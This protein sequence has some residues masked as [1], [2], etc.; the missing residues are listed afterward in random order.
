M[1]DTWLLNVFFLSMVRPKSLIL[2]IIWMS[3]PPMCT[4]GVSYLRLKIITIA[5]VLCGA[6]FNLFWTSHSCTQARARLASSCILLTD[7]PENTRTTSSANAWEYT[8]PAS[9]SSSRESSS[10]LQNVGPPIDPCTHPFWVV[11]RIVYPHTAPRLF[12]CLGSRLSVCRGFFSRI[13][14]FLV[15]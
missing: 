9:N 14:H 10:T 1:F 12:G 8:S 11:L 2:S 7:S 6:N 3:I 15:A 13:W 5:C 4:R